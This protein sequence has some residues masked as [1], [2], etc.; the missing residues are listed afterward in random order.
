MRTVIGICP[1]KPG[2]RRAIDAANNP[3][4]TVWF[5]SWRQLA[6]LLSDENRAL[7]RLMQEKQPHTV[8]ELAEWSCHAART[9]RAPCI[10]WSATAW[11]N[12]IEVR[13]HAPCAPRHWPPSFWSCSIDGKEQWIRN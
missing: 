13:T 9:C 4:P 6:S 2:R 3:T 1:A 12:C 11:S 10:T 8:L 5:D 7:L